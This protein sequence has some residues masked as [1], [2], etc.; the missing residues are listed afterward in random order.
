MLNFKWSSFTNITAMNNTRITILSQ[1]TFSSPINIDFVCA[2]TN[3]ESGISFKVTINLNL[4]DCF[5]NS[6]LI[7]GRCLLGFRIL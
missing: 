1:Y 3:T 5:E 6:F 4:N 2:S 7:I